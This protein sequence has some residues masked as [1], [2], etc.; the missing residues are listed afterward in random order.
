[1]RVERG[2]ERRSHSY[3]QMRELAVAAEAGAV[4]A[5]WGGGRRIVASRSQRGSA[6]NPRLL[7][8]G[9]QHPALT[10]RVPELGSRVATE[11]WVCVEFFSNQPRYTSNGRTLPDAGVRFMRE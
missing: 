8:I 11:T 4:P 10:A 9:P 1:M 7:L 5:A 6:P 3:A 2:D